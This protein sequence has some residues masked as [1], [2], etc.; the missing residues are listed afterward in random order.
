MGKQVSSHTHT[1]NFYMMKN[2]INKVKNNKFEKLLAIYTA[3]S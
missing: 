3:K 2:S 1:Y